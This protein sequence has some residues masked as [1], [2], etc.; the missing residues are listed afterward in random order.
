M[1]RPSKEQISELPLY[2]GLGLSDIYIVENELDAA[3][4]IEVLKNETSLG[5]D[6]ESK[7]IFQKGE[8][9][10]AHRLFNWRQSPR[11]FSFR[12]DLLSP[13]QRPRKF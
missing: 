1:E 12:F 10:P 9:S 4:A 8:V 13:L 6:T 7:P 5:F 11:R 3:Q 2:I